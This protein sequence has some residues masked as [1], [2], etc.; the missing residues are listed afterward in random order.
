MSQQTAIH[1]GLIGQG[2][3]R[4]SAPRLHRL[5][6]KHLGLAVDYGLF[7]L[8]A[9][10]DF[11]SCLQRCQQAGLTGVNI[12]HPFKTLA[13]QQATWLAEDVAAIGAINTILF[14]DEGVL[15]GHN[16]DWSGFKAAYRARFGDAAAGRVA[17]LGAGG[18]G[19]PI[20][21]ALQQLGATELHIFDRDRQAAERLAA[22][23]RSP[24]CPI[25]VCADAAS[26]SAAVDG[27]INATPIG[28]H[29][30]PG[31]PLP[32]DCFGRPAWAFDAI[33]TPIDT[34]FLR[35]AKAAGAE[36]LSGYELFL[37]QGIDAFRLFTGRQIGI[38]ELRELLSS[39]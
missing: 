36:I 19:R 16:T 15:S 14:T 31:C 38:M 34:P 22:D 29:N 32:V 5:S 20:A 13:F 4:S 24:N 37:H 27:L 33:Y 9:P 25:T 12:T 10:G 8:A 28:M 30:H 23:L 2:I 1:L 26:A 17:I 35:H 11:A 39:P 21:A 7:D 3:S 18:V 6:G